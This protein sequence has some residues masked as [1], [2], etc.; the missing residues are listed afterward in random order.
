M[1]TVTLRP[2]ANGD[3]VQWNAQYP[4]SDEHWDKVDEE[5][6]DDGT[7]YIQ[8]GAAGQRV[9]LFSHAGYVGSGRISD[10]RVFARNTVAAGGGSYS[11]WRGAIKTYGNV[12]YSALD[13]Y[14]SIFSWTLRHWHWAT[15][16]YTG[17]IWKW[18]EVNALQFGLATW[19]GAG[20]NSNMCT[21]IYIEVDYTPEPGSSNMFTGSFF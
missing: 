3:L 13:T 4:A 7:T 2:S 8:A 19:N 20:T 1:T 11:Y 9:D 18:S 6:A 10:L 16:P 14:S 5:E 21:Q 12:Y 15:N 17:I